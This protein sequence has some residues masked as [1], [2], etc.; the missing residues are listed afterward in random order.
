MT[1]AQRA[2]QA[3]PFFPTF[4]RPGVFEAKAWGGP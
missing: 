1:R 2:S 4:A 3:N